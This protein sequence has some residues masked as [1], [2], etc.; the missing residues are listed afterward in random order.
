MTNGSRWSAMAAAAPDR[1]RAFS[2]RATPF[3]TQPRA[4]RHSHSPSAAARRSRPLDAVDA[5]DDGHSRAHPLAFVYRR[6]RQ[7]GAVL[8]HGTCERCRMQHQGRVFEGDRRGRRQHGAVL[9]AAVV[10]LAG[11]QNLDLP[12]DAVV[13]NAA[14]Q[15]R[16]VRPAVLEELRDAPAPAVVGV[17]RAAPHL[18][19]QARLVLLRRR[20]AR[21][22]RRAR[23]FD[24]GRRGVS[25]CGDRRAVY[26]CCRGRGRPSFCSSLLLLWWC[27]RAP[28]FLRP[29]IAL[30]SNVARG[31][32]SGSLAARAAAGVYVGLSVAASTA[33]SH[34]SGRLREC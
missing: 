10:R 15:R 8:R 33:L 4:W 21:A 34:C 1:R 20:D 27:A 11:H 6:V 28:I 3:P 24:C 14:V 32:A 30:M 7:H 2:P 26:L 13:Q 5:G 18:E 19:A 22:G 29:G 16:A 17:Q 31:M 25:I 12:R 9:D 23:P